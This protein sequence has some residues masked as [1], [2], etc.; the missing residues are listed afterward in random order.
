MKRKQDSG[1]GFTLFGFLL[2]FFTI[3]ITSTSAI[4]VY[5]FA[6]KTHNHAVIIFSVLGVI[7]VGAVLCSLCDLI[8]RKYMVEKP[9]KMILEATEKIAA[10]D[11]DVKLEPL[12]EYDRYDEYDLIF[13]NIN[14]MSAEL[15]KNELLK[16][17]FIS[18]ISHEI[19]TPLAVI[20][21]YVRVLQDG[22]LSKKT[23][24]QCLQGLTVQTQKLS[25]LITNILKLNKLENQNIKPDM[26][27]FDLAEL[28]RVT[29]LQFENIIDKKNLN[30]ECNID[31]V[32]ITSSQSLLEIVINNLVSNAVKFTDEGGVIGVSLQQDKNYAIIKISDTGCGISQEVGEHIFDKFY[33]GDTSHSQEGNGLGLALVKRVIDILGG[34][35][36]VSS[37]VGEGT[38]FTLKLK[39]G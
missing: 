6:Y 1:V 9:T 3:L 28:L 27:T 4:F 14:T 29:T 5:Y 17:D 33:Q 39:K 26:Q 21:N 13:D 16:N 25:G 20:Q 24:E 2:F 19:K 7:I 34:E 23:K 8:R 15:S 36:G 37:K 10:G 18:N 11:F 38:T 31:E 12:H 30:L 35:I 22:K 32:S